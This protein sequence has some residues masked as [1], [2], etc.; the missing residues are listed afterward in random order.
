MRAAVPT[1]ELERIEENLNLQEPGVA[2]QMVFVIRRLQ[3]SKGPSDSYLWDLLGRARCILGDA[4]RSIAGHRRSVELAPNDPVRW[5]NFAVS[6]WKLH[7]HSEALDTMHRAATH[8]YEMANFYLAQWYYRLHRPDVA[9]PL[10][11]GCVEASPTKQRF[12][13]QALIL[14]ALH[15]PDEAR[16]VALQAMRAFTQEF[17]A[18]WQPSEEETSKAFLAFV[19]Q[20]CGEWAGIRMHR[21]L[22]GS[23]EPNA[24]NVRRALLSRLQETARENPLPTP[25]QGAVGTGLDDW[26]EI[27]PLAADALSAGIGD[28]WPV[29]KR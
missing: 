4:E 5:F 14:D 27:F 26:A 23:H 17:H 20:S 29:G 21:I 24:E 15:R 9:L 18:E 28:P 1:S 2:S 22:L 3:Q 25:G 13:W 11:E 6:L 12:A 16:D 19:S 8:D 10:V 7:R